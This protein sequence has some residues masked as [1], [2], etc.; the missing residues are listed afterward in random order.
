MNNDINQIIVKPSPPK[1]IQIDY[2]PAFYFNV[3]SATSCTRDSTFNTRVVYLGMNLLS[4]VNFG[5]L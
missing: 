1:K 2:P 4:A 5:L 3:Q